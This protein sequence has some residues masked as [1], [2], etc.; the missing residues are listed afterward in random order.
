MKTIGLFLVAVVSLSL[1]SSFAAGY[2]G[3][4]GSPADP[5]Q[6]ASVEDFMAMTTAEGDWGAALS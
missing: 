3:G 2:N 5:F 6:I 4:I 1:F